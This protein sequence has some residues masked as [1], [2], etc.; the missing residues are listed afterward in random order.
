MLEGGAQAAGRVREAGGANEGEGVLSHA[1]GEHAGQQRRGA[2]SATGGDGPA[3]RRSVLRHRPYR[4]QR[5]AGATGPGTSTTHGS[6]P[7][8][9]TPTQPGS[10]P[11]PA[12][13][14][15]DP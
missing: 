12:C 5:R 4:G 9:T 6:S 15:S 3:P 2:A 10:N 13:P 1:F 11:C 7:S 14:P 8:P